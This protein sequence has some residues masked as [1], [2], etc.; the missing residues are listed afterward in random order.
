MQ[1]TEGDALQWLEDIS[2]KHG[3]LLPTKYFNPRYSDL[4]GS[5]IPRENGW[6]DMD[7]AFEDTLAV[8]VQPSVRHGS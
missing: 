3:G 5:H 7:A 4:T 2:K 8:S 1:I 6:E